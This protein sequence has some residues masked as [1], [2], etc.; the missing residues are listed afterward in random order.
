MKHLFTK[1]HYTAILF[2]LVLLCNPNFHT[3]DILPD[4][5]GYFLLALS[6]GYAADIA[7]YFTEMRTWLY[8]LGIVTLV[9]VPLTLVMYGNMHSGRDIVPLF[10]LVFAILELICLIPLIS[11]A[12]N[13]LS[14]LGQRSD[15]K[16]LIYPVK[17]FGIDFSLNGLRGFTTLFVVLKAV[18]NTLPTTCLLT[19]T[20]ANMAKIAQ[21]IY[22]PF[23]LTSL[24]VVLIFGIVW[25]VVA[26][27]YVKAVRRE[28]GV[29]DGLMAMA[30][31]IKLE[32]IERKR[33]QGSLLGGVTLLFVSMFLTFDISFRQTNNIN[34]LPHFIFAIF[35]FVAFCR[36]CSDRKLHRI[37]TVAF[38]LCVLFGVV[39]QI[40]TWVF[41]NNYT[42]LDILE[43]KVAKDMY[44]CVEI[45]SVVE[46]ISFLVY[47]V[48]LAL[49][50]AWSIRQ[51]TGTDPNEEGYSRAS[52]DRHFRLTV[53]GVALFVI[54][55]LISISKCV[56]VFLWGNPHS[57][58][59]EG[60]DG[61]IDIMAEPT[62]SWFGTLIFALSVICV[63]YGY[64]FT[65]ELKDEIRMKYDINL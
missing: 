20:D 8:R 45:C 14:Y 24:A 50:L 43:L 1:K 16:S 11:N 38:A 44:L 15:V 6:I 40:A 32:E 18:L 2:S 29:G 39:Y 25:C 9:K 31:E 55:A 52:K 36:L 10:T 63:I 48:F 13:G 17:I 21:T 22:A 3:V 30:T 62:F 57:E 51:N 33:K 4:F 58:F 35:I 34:I 26:F 54:L 42:Y 23:E 19:Y 56:N 28:G 37:L 61:V 60:P 46:T 59:T 49:S 27:T 41:F 12:Y 65:N 64:L 53:K 7:P 47:Y 5:I